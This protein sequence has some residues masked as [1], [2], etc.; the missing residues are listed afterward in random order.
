[1]GGLLRYLVRQLLVRSYQQ[2][3]VQDQSD[4]FAAWHI[5]PAP[6]L[7]AYL[8]VL[9]L[10]MFRQRILS[11][12]QGSQYETKRYLPAKPRFVPLE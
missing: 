11:G 2:K 6:I 5:S 10:L 1:M 8:P 4:F 7:Q 3:V 9:V 12:T